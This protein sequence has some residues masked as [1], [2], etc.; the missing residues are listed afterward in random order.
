LPGADARVRLVL[1]GG[2]GGAAYDISEALTAFGVAD[3]TV[4]TGFLPEQYLPVAYAAASLFVYPSL[5]EG[6]GLPPLEAMASGTPVIVAN[7]TSLPEVVGDAGVLV[8]PT[9]PHDLAR[10]MRL[11]L[12]DEGERRRRVAA[13]LRWVQQF[14]WQRAA[15]E[16]L[17]AYRQALE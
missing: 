16:T 12:T 9:D 4:V 11:L 14:S 7:A 5:Y 2:G 6:F 8:D 13:G 10:Q 17:A 3:R 15:L 1:A